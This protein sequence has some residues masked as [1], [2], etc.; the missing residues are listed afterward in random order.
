M[1][2]EKILIIGACGQLG[3]ELTE[4]LR[5][6][7]GN[8]QVIASDIRNG[9]DPVFQTGPF[10]I[11][12]V[13]DKN[14]IGEVFA[15]YKPTQVY[16]LAALLS[17][18]AEQQPKFGWTLNMDGLFNIFDA[19]L[20]YK[21]AKVYWPSS[22]AV[23]GPNTPRDFTPQYCVMD[24]TTVYGI[25]KLAGERY[26]EY[27]FKRYGLDVR[28]L[29][30]PGLIGY[31]SAPG[32]GTTDYAV[33]IYH[34]ALSKGVHECFL[35]ENTTLPMLYMP[36]ALKATIGLMDAPANQVV[37]RSSYNLAG[38]SFSPLEITN[39]IQKHIPGFS[40]IYK[41]DQRQAIADSWPKV[42][43]DLSA[44]NDWGW[45]PDFNL[46]RMTEDMLTNLK[47]QYAQGI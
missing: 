37:I 35:S 11:L 21:V 22:I 28:S 23:F 30:Y 4:E 44:Q 13:L 15:K 17:A 3:T 12:D 5:N 18:T 14:K 16:H 39:A 46:D 7:Y 24:P 34:D 47:K 36:D 27:Y 25:S 31:K 38:M 32:G 6:L 45:K 10:E 26:C 9:N 42:I 41:P 8:T 20:E 2:S 19:A 43:D 40:T 29:R 1:S 33:S